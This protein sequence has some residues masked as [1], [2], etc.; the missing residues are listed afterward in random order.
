MGSSI[1]I[2]A[3]EED[4]ILRLSFQ[5][6]CLVVTMLFLL[7]PSVSFASD[8]YSSGDGAICDKVGQACFDSYGVSLGITKDEF[9]QAAAD[10]IE[11]NIEEAGDQWDPSVF[12]LS[13]GVSCDTKKKTCDDSYGNLDKHMTKTLFG[14]SAV[15]EPDHSKMKAVVNGHCKLY[16]KKSDNNKY[17][18]DC[19]IK[20]KVSDGVN[21]FVIKLGSGDT[22]RFV[23]QGT[24]YEVHTPNGV[25]D[26]KAQMTD[27]G[28]KAVF[29]W[30][31]WELTA[32][33]N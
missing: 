7:L 2:P 9:G 18:G 16:N 31:K 26:H 17:K 11:R 12:T 33:E 4:M 27:Y 15:K 5:N 13:N 21:E 23:Q 6:I 22:Y 8:V 10:K 14:T 20:Q 28:R 3:K 25:S 1:I 32:K 30:Y 24:T 29:E 19:R